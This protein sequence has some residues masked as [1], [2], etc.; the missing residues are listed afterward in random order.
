MV[1]TEGLAGIAEDEGC[2]ACAIIG[3]DAN[4]GNGN[5]NGKAIG[6]SDCCLRE[7]A[8]TYCFLV[9]EE[10]GE[11]DAGGIIDV[12]DTLSAFRKRSRAW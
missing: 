8:G 9:G 4:D 11:A 2:V 7:G 3:H 12:S 5:G 10:V 6:I 1:Q